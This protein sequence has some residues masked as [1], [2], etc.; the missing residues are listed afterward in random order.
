[1]N[2]VRGER[3]SGWADQT[4]SEVL[5]RHGMVATSQP[6]AAQAGLDILKQGGNAVDAAV[7]AAAELALIE[8]ESTGLGGDLFAQVYMAGE[9]KLYGLNASGWAPGAW[10]RVVL[11]RQVRR[12]APVHG[13]GLRDR[14]GRRRRLGEAA[15]TASG[16]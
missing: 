5:A 3:A 4:R 7:A 11:P 1:M 14:A 12:R 6:L 13:R 16:T 2:A 10:T 8:P 9:S 15:A